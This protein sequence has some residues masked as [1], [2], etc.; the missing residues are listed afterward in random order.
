[1][2]LLGSKKHSKLF[3][4]IMEKNKIQLDL[5]YKVRLNKIEDMVNDLA[6]AIDHMS[7]DFDLLKSLLNQS[8]TRNQENLDEVLNAIENET[9]SRLKDK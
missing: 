4:L 1:M 8:K 9:D 5:T 7:K 3:G 6:N 2:F